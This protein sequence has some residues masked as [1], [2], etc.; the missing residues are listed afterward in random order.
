[1]CGRSGPQVPATALRRRLANAVEWGLDLAVLLFFP[2][3]I[4]AP[5]GIAALASVAGMF[6]AALILSAK[7][8]LWRSNLAVPASLV[9]ALL[10]WG[11]VS[12]LWSIDPLRSLNLAARLAGLFAAGLALAGAADEVT[13][14][15]R[16]TGFLLAGFVLGITM[17]ALDLASHGALSKPFSTRPYEPSWLNQASVAF[18]ILLPPTGA[19][20]VGFGRRAAG[21]LFA[22]AVA[23]T[24][25][26]LVGTAAKVSLAVGL[27]AALLCYG[28]RAR[29]ARLAAALSVIVVIGAPLTFARLERVSDLVATANEVKQSAGHRLLIWS[30]V[31]NRIAEHPLAGWGLNSSRAIPGGKDLIRPG[32]SWLPLHPHDAP[33]QLWLELGVPGAVLMALLSA[34]AWLALA[35]ADLPRL[36]GGA[37]AGS[38]ACAFVATLATYGIWE[39]WWQG[40]LWF[41]LFLVLVMARVAAASIP[42]PDAH[43]RSAAIR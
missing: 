1:M 15:G 3:L 4:L 36:Y 6:A 42:V 32:E 18:A 30:F 11:A 28:W 43:S 41:C 34:H 31:G 13:A 37:A 21:V 26:A 19:V 7:R 25:L 40:T 20:L 27:G 14:P 5:R 16:L 10:V 2:L 12:A 38:L 33:L 39:E 9:G 8:P 29:M 22:G 24:V 17:A 35:R 23:V